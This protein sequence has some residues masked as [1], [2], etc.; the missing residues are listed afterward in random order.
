M[1]MLSPVSPAVALRTRAA[2]VAALA[3]PAVVLLTTLACVALVF[4]LLVQT[5]HGG[6]VGIVLLPLL[7]AT[8]RVLVPR[9]G[10]VIAPAPRRVAAPE[11]IAALAPGE[12]VW[13]TADREIVATADGLLVGAF[14][15]AECTPEQLREGI[16]AAR[17]DRADTRARRLRR[18]HAELVERA[19]L[20]ASEHEVASL[21]WA[22]F[23]RLAD[24]RCTRALAER[25]AP[26]TWRDDHAAGFEAYWQS[27]VT[28][29]LEGGYRPPLLEQWRREHSPLPADVD[30]LEA[31][32]LGDGEL[33]PL[34][35]ERFADAVL[36]PYARRVAGRAGL[37]EFAVSDLAE[38]AHDAGGDPERQFQLSCAL[39]VALAGAGWE[40]EA[41]PGDSVRAV[42]DGAT[43]LPFDVPYAL[44]GGA[45]PS[46]D[47]FVAEEGIAGLGLDPI[48]PLDGEALELETLLA[49]P[50]AAPTGARVELSLAGPR[51]QRV[52]ALL[53]A[54]VAALLGAP[55]AV[56]LVVEAFVLDLPPAAVVSMAV[57]GVALGALLA[58]WTRS[59]IRLARATGRLVVDADRVVI[60]HPVLLRRPFELPR[61]SVRALVL[62]TGPACHDELGRRV[63]LP[64]AAAPWEDAAELGR[65]WTAGVGSMVPL[66]AVEPC[67]PN[68]ALV[69]SHRVPAPDVRRER[70]SGPLRGEAVGGLLLTAAEVPPD[71]VAGLARLGFPNALTREDA[72]LLHGAFAAPAPR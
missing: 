67:V 11:A 1:S 53:V 65:L 57:A 62:D 6:P 21:P 72:H 59:R 2:L 43:L 32:L 64:V 40:I 23:A 13:L 48:S 47:M 4:A 24:R 36:V 18:L 55:L 31:E 34:P 52:R 42:G 68:L 51:S 17:H 30:A 54:L 33:V 20:A 71:A 8:A 27:Y 50:A 9:R 58:W 63:T 26:V 60:E 37:H 38:L 70:T 41:V 14:A 46:W 44:A 5:G 12:P 22:W 49:A 69:L 29:C 16:A 25:A 19:R 10:R 15:A 35:W 56:L 28:P 7:V 39:V 45:S 61:T 66:L 3:V